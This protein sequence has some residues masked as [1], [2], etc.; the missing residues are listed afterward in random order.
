MKKMKKA[1]YDA[2]NERHV[3]STCGEEGAW[4]HLVLVLV[5]HKIARLSQAHQLTAWGQ[6]FVVVRW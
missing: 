5:P 6:C 1:E 3:L 4:T 2:A